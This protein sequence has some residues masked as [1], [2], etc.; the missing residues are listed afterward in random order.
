MHTRDAAYL[1]RAYPRFA[2]FLR[3]RDETDPLRVFANSYTQQVFGA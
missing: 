2:D 1:S 3:I